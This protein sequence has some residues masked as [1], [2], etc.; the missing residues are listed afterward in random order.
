M[1]PATASVQPSS[2]FHPTDAYYQPGRTGH[3]SS[4]DSQCGSSGSHPYGDHT[5]S[6]SD[7]HDGPPPLQANYTSSPYLYRDHTGVHNKHHKAGHPAFSDLNRMSPIPE[8]SYNPPNRTASYSAPKAGPVI[9]LHSTNSYRDHHRQASDTV[10][11]SVFGNVSYE[12]L[13]MMFYFDHGQF[14][15]I[16]TARQLQTMIS[17]ANNVVIYS[18]FSNGAMN[19]NCLYRIVVCVCVNFC[20]KLTG[21]S[22]R[23]LRSVTMTITDDCIGQSWNTTC[24]Q[25]FETFN[26]WMLWW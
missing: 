25:L 3:D 20:T 7:H 10:V 8:V 21:K 23:N 22:S 6:Q 15:G 4:I 12:S 11:W 26:K 5:H 14:K 19:S 13:M 18:L 2:S 1:H 9:N 24:T 16:E 17:I